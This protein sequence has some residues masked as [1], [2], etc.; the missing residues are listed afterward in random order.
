MFL[1]VIFL[2]SMLGIVSI[3]L[4]ETCNINT[5]KCCFGTNCCGCQ[6]NMSNP[7]PTET[8]IP[9]CLNSVFSLSQLSPL[10]SPYSIPRSYVISPVCGQTVDAI[11]SYPSCFIDDVITPA[12]LSGTG[13][14][15]YNQ[16]TNFVC[17]Y[18]KALTNFYVKNTCMTNHVEACLALV[19][20]KLIEKQN[21]Q[22]CTTME[23]YQEWVHNTLKNNPQLNSCRIF[24]VLVNFNLGLRFGPNCVDFGLLSQ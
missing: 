2:L 6:E 1:S 3:A 23:Q 24:N 20:D 21:D 7:S 19:K 22:T 11:L 18:Y 15:V 17:E 16:N 13:N 5:T 8:C 9:I 4:S 10:I 12:N 14:T